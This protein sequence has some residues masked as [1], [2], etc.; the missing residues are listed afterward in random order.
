[1]T[2]ASVTFP[3]FVHQHYCIG[4]HG[5]TFLPLYHVAV[6]DDLENL[7]GEY[8]RILARYL[9]V[10]K[11]AVSARSP[12]Y[13]ASMCRHTA[14]VVLTRAVGS[15]GSLGICLADTR[16]YSLIGHNNR[17]TGLTYLALWMIWTL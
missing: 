17:N 16:N 15:D 7:I 10:S 4:L 5:E 14:L 12:H 1:M 8:Y 3:F 9:T 11:A 2:K 13:D 6:G